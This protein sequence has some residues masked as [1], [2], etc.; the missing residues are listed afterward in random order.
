MAP[1]S[2]QT[3]KII[4]DVSLFALSQVAFYFAFKVSRSVLCPVVIRTLVCHAF[5]RS[6]RVVLHTD[7]AMRIS[8]RGH[9]LIRPL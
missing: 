3:R 2:L 5:P 8:T 6:L 7:H 9:D 1:L 4:A